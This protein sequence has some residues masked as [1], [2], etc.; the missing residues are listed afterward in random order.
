MFKP[1]YR[2][3]DSIINNIA[4]ISEAREAILLSP[5]LPKVESK[6]RREA[7]ISRTHHSTSI[8]GNPLNLPQVKII[9]EGGKLVARKKDK[10]EI[11]NYL[12]ALK[13]LEKTAKKK[14]LKTT[15]VIKIQKLVTKNILSPE[16]C[17]KYRDRMVYVVNSF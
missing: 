14:E 7:L 5:I 13:Y 9:A 1:N 15:T 10:Q 12:S 8:E 4:S 6:L 2:A 17:G 16:D 3:T 11:T